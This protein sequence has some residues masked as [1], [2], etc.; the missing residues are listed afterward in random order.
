MLELSGLSRQE[1]L[2]IKA[3]ATD[4]NQFEMIASTL[5]QHYG[6][7]H[8]RENSKTWNDKTPGDSKGNK[9]KGKTYSKSYKRVGYV[10]IEE[11]DGSW[12]DENGID[13]GDDD[14]SWYAGF[15][16]DEGNPEQREHEHEDYEFHD[17]VDEYDV[18]ALNA[19][20]ELDMEDNPR[21]IGEVIQLQQAAFAAFGKA[22]G[23]GFSKKGKSKGKGKMVRSA[24]SLDQRRAK[25]VGLKARSKCLRCGGIGH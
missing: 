9:G 4:P 12:N 15:W 10:G 13:Q 25:L 7:I 3:C 11:E 8:L 19:I 21:Q 5:I 18:I 20:V 23:K 1:S 24:L 16:A 14:N 6:S 17:D 22:K 2:V